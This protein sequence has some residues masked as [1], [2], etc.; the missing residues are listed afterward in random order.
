MSKHTLLLADDSV[1]IQKVVNLTFAD[2]G[3]DVISVGDGNSAMEKF[4][5]HSP[6]LVMVDVNMPGLDGYRICEMIK[7][8][9]E[10]K[11]VPVI[12][13]V[14]SFE[15]FDENE[16][17]RVGANDYLT[18]PF[19]S[20]RQLVNKVTV[21]L[22]KSAVNGTA[23]SSEVV[24][25]AP[26]PDIP[27]VEDIKTP[28]PLGDAGMD[29][30]MIQSSQIGSL[31]AEE[32]RK[33]ET[34]A[35]ETSAE[36]EPTPTVGYY[37]SGNSETSA[38]TQPFS[39]EEIREFIPEAG[40][41]VE[42]G[43]QD[44]V[45]DDERAASL[46]K[47]M[48]SEFEI[49]AKSLADE[50][51][52]EARD[53]LS[54][55]EDLEDDYDGEIETAATEIAPEVFDQAADSEAVANETGTAEDDNGSGWEIYTPQKDVSFVEPES[56]FEDRFK[57]PAED[58][59][60]NNETFEEP[61]PDDSEPVSYG[62]TSFDDSET[63]YSFDD[64]SF[65]TPE[66]PITNDAYNAVTYEPPVID[67]P[68]ETQFSEIVVETP[69]V[70]PQFE[71]IPAEESNVFQAPEEDS[72]DQQTSD[73]SPAAQ[74]GISP[75]A[76]RDEFGETPEA[77]APIP[78]EPESL[79]ET[80][81][82]APEPVTEYETES[83]PEAVSEYR[84]EEAEIPAEAEPFARFEDGEQTETVTAETAA[85]STVEIPLPTPTIEES[86]PEP[87]VKIPETPRETSHSAVSSLVSG[88][89]KNDAVESVIVSEFA[90]HSI[91]LSS[92]A[93][94]TIAAR[95]AE[96]ISEKIVQQLATDVVTDL[97]DLIVD[98]MERRNL[99]K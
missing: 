21:L 61:E 24:N 84:T 96:K 78:F 23:A 47:Q 35:D 25:A 92:E 37:D 77:S 63:A 58:A 55:T 90:R 39:A 60:E 57:T 65:E 9:D 85:P 46:E 81:D 17:R 26:E 43:E 27:P 94:E 89:E 98:R 31:P 91:S 88:K 10:T 50:Y 93:V 41:S 16:A 12:L 73:E 22:S 97:A 71:Q 86:L 34:E 53:S 62:E 44:S 49:E 8:D 56:Y 36:T 18:K 54:K 1:T 32:S 51:R 72:F 11:H 52:S 14:G 38:K 13:L 82:T 67:E 80:F 45:S 75:S 68:Q 15:P 5:E 30:E 7:Q 95:I 99:E 64:A 6:D 19:Q 87:E 69:D 59:Y 70:E 4:V 29:D 28:D 3:I 2:E 20:I 76:F 40:K 42:P 79:S 83:E 48:V 33:F 74:P 66:E